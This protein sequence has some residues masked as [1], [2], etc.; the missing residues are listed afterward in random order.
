MFLYMEN[1]DVIRGTF[2][3]FYVRDEKQIYTQLAC[4]KAVD[5]FLE[6]KN[7]LPELK[8]QDAMSKVLPSFRLYME[9]YALFFELYDECEIESILLKMGTYFTSW[10]GLGNMVVNATFRFLKNFYNEQWKEE[11]ILQ[12]EKANIYDTQDEWIEVG[13]HLG[14]FISDMFSFKNSLSHL[15]Y[16]TDAEM[17]MDNTV[18]DFE[19][20][21]AEF[22][23]THPVKPP[24]T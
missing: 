9:E 19:F 13:R 23:E 15:D 16:I 2:I 1:D 22:Y 18:E 17:E 14:D 24:K 20:Y 21:T 3:G 10:S 12:I 11:I 7:L 8:G 5:G 4:Y 6:V